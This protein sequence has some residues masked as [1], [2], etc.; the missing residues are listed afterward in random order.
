MPTPARL[1]A[2]LATTTGLLAALPAVASAELAH[3]QI[4]IETE[5][6]NHVS[7][8]GGFQPQKDPTLAAALR[9]FGAVTDVR[10][11]GKEV[12][13][14]SW[15]QHGVTITFVNLGGSD[16]CDP[17]FGKAQFIYVG[18][19]AAR[20]WHTDRDLY[21][22]SA[23][24]SM[25]RLYRQQR[26]SDRRYSLVRAYSRYGGDETLDLLNVGLTHDRISSF[27]MYIGAAGE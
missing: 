5:G 13:A 18:G 2:I 10:R 22:T 1:L 21:I 7:S 3:H 8:I 24:S 23:Q 15:G 16:A 14:V 17:Q 4:T 25:K 9:R 27:R 11:D 20:G 6:R 12:C 26:R 19:Q